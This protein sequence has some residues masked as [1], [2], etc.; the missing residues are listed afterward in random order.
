VAKKTSTNKIINFNWIMDFILRI[1][2]QYQ[3]HM[4]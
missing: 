4:W 2:D 1:H 3:M